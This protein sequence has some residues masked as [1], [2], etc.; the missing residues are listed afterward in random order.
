[1]KFHQKP[2]GRGKKYLAAFALLVIVGFVFVNPKV[3]QFLSSFS[4][5]IG[6]PLWGARAFFLDEVAVAFGSLT[7]EETLLAENADLRKKISLLEFQDLTRKALL[8]ENR[9]LKAF[10]GRTNEENR[11]LAG[12]IL[13]PPALAYDT[14]ILDAGKEQ[15]VSEGA[16]VYFSDDL[17]LGRV[18]SAFDTSSEVALF[19]SSGIETDVLIG[20]DSIA[21]VAK[22][23]GG[24]NYTISLP[25]DV[26]IEEGMRYICQESA[27]VFLELCNQ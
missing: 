2:K 4:H 10:L 20:A 15:G 12:I 14:L 18:Q 1:M 27:I 22:G 23:H 25:R 8:V 7:S 3:P 5:G 11:V 6:A 24:G 26:V 13:R 21:A 16:L 9:E 19:S 17:V